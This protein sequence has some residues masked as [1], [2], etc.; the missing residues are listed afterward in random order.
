MT[1]PPKP[2]LTPHLVTAIHHPDPNVTAAM[3]ATFRFW[4]EGPDATREGSTFQPHPWVLTLL[5]AGFTLP[6]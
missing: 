2:F 6:S 3:A 1:T 5:R 4:L